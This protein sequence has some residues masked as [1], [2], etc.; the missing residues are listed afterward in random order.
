MSVS[1]HNNVV[2]GPEEEYIPAHLSYGQFMFDQLKKGGDNI[3]LISADTE[4]SMTYRELLQHSVDLAV[5]LRK[6]GLKKND[7]VALSSENRFEFLIAALA[8]MYNGGIL[9]VLNITYTPGEITHMLHIIKPKYIFVSPLAAQNI[10]D[11]C[12]EVSF[13]EKLIMFGEYEVVPS[14]MYNDLV[15]EHV[16]V[17]DL[18][19]VDVNGK[20]DTL[21][22]MCSSG[23]TGL[24]KGVMLTHVNILTSTAH[25]KYYFN[26]S[27]KMTNHEILS[28]LSLIPWFHA[29]GFITTFT[30]LALRIKIVYLTTFE[31]QQYLETIQKYKINMT[32]I[33]PPLAVFLAKD[34]LVL[35]HNLNSLNEV[36]C[37]AAPLSAD[38]QKAISERTGL[39]YIKNGYGLTEVTMACCV[40]LTGG[41]KV[42]SC[43]IPGPGMKIKVI[44]LETGK[45]LGPGKEGEIC[46]KSALR[47]KGYQGDTAAGD[48]LLDHEGF[49][50]TGD[51]GYYDADGY[52][53]IVDRLKELIKYKGFQVAP[54]ELEALLLR[55]DGVTDCGVVGAPDALAGELPLAFVV[56]A[57]GAAVTEADLVQYVASKVSSA[58]HL[59]GGVRFVDEIPKNPAGKILRRELRKMIEIPKSKL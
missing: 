16:N 32:A 43:G 24:P 46:V 44:D 47:M 28:A 2:T 13:V 4:K 50:R 5:A 37:G 26:S 40:D 41:D 36:W 21:A 20:E 53:Y 59:R 34:P 23:T 14:L 17:D 51:I 10:Y 22:I 19:L 8:V 54:A 9:S 11:A 48:A 30:I 6:L 27:I 3:A 45:K 25:M 15:K 58:K 1:I 31:P 18:T 39:K 42:G 35:K 55:H 7:V 52:I 56:R 57:P 29:Y 38:I 33:V 12:Q 49:I